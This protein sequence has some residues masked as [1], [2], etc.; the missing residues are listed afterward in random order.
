MTMRCNEPGWEA[1]SVPDGRRGLWLRFNLPTGKLEVCAGREGDDAYVVL[2]VGKRL[3][4]KKLTSLID[5]L[6]TLQ[7]S[8]ELAE[9]REPKSE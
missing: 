5:C 7:F 6:L 9:T 4:Q 8:A 1:I 2:S 3:T